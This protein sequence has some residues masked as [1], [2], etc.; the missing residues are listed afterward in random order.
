MPETMNSVA[1][2]R[3]CS[4]RVRDLKKMLNSDVT[5]V[6]DE[7]RY[8]FFCMSHDVCA[9]CFGINWSEITAAP[10][11]RGTKWKCLWGRWAVQ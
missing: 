8:K 10:M 4:N 6:P 11:Q 7:F 1:P 2:S 9:S 5:V 3:P